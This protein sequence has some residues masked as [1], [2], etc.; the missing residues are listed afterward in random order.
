MGPA[1]QHSRPV[2]VSV[3]RSRAVKR[4]KD[5]GL[6]LCL[7]VVY[8]VLLSQGLKASAGSTFFG[9]L[10]AVPLTLHLYRRVWPVTSDRERL[11]GPATIQAT[12]R[13]AS[14]D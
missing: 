14:T 3:E 8:C 1:K 10:A 13:T 7:F 11:E 2:N 5:A 9:A 4:A 12:S 6:V